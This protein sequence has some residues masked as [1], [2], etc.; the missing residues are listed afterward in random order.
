M[1]RLAWQAAQIACVLKEQNCWGTQ[2]GRC[3]Q[4]AGKKPATPPPRL[5][6]CIL[7]TSTPPSPSRKEGQ[8]LTT[9][10]EQGNRTL[11]EGWRS[12]RNCLKS[13]TCRKCLKDVIEH[14]WAVQR[15]YQLKPW[16][17]RNRT[18]RVCVCVCVCVCACVHVTPNCGPTGGMRLWC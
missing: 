9:E 7:Q 15:E 12:C 3:L 2:R 4:N 14:I 13:Y 6:S 10:R 18:V 1:E 16:S 5:F 11:E 8:Q 17:G